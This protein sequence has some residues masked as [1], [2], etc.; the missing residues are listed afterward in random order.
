[1]DI[2]DMYQLVSFDLPPGARFF[3]VALYDDV[4]H[5]WSKLSNFV[6]SPEPHKPGEFT[7]IVLES[8][9]NL[10]WVDQSDHEMM[11]RVERMWEDSGN[12]YLV[13]LADLSDSSAIEGTAYVDDTVVVSPRSF[14]ELDEEGNPT[15][16]LNYG[17]GLRYR[18]CAVAWSDELDDYF[19]SE[20]VYSSWI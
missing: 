20:W 16:V 8:Q 14:Y 10:H 6:E 2:V 13:T 11:F 15:Y 1:M 4:N 19:Y 3:A 12:W 9:V 18:V 7:A 5:R 17:L